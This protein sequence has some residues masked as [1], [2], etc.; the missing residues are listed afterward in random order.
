MKEKYN[1]ILEVD[2]VVP[3]IVQKRAEEAYSQIKERGE[4]GNMNK[5]NIISIGM[6]SNRKQKIIKTL[7]AV[8]AC[9]ALFIVV[10]KLSIFSTF[11]EVPET[12]NAETQIESIKGDDDL[13][14]AL[15]NMFTLKAYAAEHPE[16]DEN[17]Y[18]SLNDNNI[19][20]EENGLGSVLCEGEDGFVSYCIGTDFLCEGENI[21]S[22]TY[23]ING[24]AFQVVERPNAS[25]L[26]AKE[27]YG[28]NLNTG[29]CGGEDSDTLDNPISVRGFYKSITLSYDNQMN[30][31]TWINICNETEYCWDFLYGEGMTLEE[32]VSAIEEMMKDVEILCTVQYTDGT[33]DDAR[34]T[35]GGGVHVLQTGVPEKDEPIADFEFRLEP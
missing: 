6:K 13:I 34:I 7:A 27:P 4:T 22:I 15:E 2:I 21:E 33:T 24:A 30:D 9:A 17:G 35:V 11:N 18:V 16:A 3:D 8:C 10:G 19:L 28:K 31:Y 29:T 5:N 23:S 32:R 25:I 14:H 20:V 26:I 12:N 1:N